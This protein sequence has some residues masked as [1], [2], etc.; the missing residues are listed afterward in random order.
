MTDEGECYIIAHRAD[1]RQNEMASVK[2]SGSMPLANTCLDD[3]KKRKKKKAKKPKREKSD[4][5]KS[6]PK[7]KQGLKD[8]SDIC[9]TIFTADWPEIKKKKRKKKHGCSLNEEFFLT[10]NKNLKLSKRNKLNRKTR[11]VA[12][13]RAAKDGVRSQPG[14]QEAVQ[15][16]KSLIR[17]EKKHNKRVV[18]NLPPVLLEPKPLQDPFLVRDSFQTQHSNA[19]F[20]ADGRHSKPA[21]EE[22]GT[23][24]Q[25]TS[26]DI[27]SQDL[28]ITQKTFSDPYID[29]C[30]STSA[31]EAL[32]PQG[33]TEIHPEPQ[34]YTASSEKEPSREPQSYTESVLRKQLC[35]EHQYYTSSCPD[36][37]ASTASLTK[38]HLYP[39]HHTY[40]VPLTRNS[41]CSEPQAPIASS[42]K[43]LSS[44]EPQ[45]YTSSSS[46]P[47]KWSCPEPQSLPKK[48]LCPH[49]PSY[50]PSPLRKL[51]HGHKHDAFTQTE[52]FFTAPLLATSLGFRQQSKCTEEPMD[53]SL[54]KRPQREAVR[55]A[56][57][58][59]RIPE[60]NVTN[61][62]QVDDSDSYLK[63]KADLSQLKVVQTRLNESF[64]FKLKGEGDSPKPMSPLM[65]LAGSVEKKKP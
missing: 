47:R 43:K 56:S 18:F 64:F 17:K 52:N 53:L 46:S 8:Y 26:D 30:S 57:G 36:P 16:I 48:P 1:V 21:M 12:D 2:V 61:L 37:Q 60:P 58:D 44:P 54:P 59:Q 65:K 34:S 3:P 50:H 39:V 14:E 28:F 51:S 6:K 5:H 38:K 24:S 45:S 4:K 13:S 11:G 20:P 10:Q 63:S 15:P 35:P 31:E 49:H 27:N 62:T 19:R 42:A 7:G 9:D 41:P 33:Y 22:N 23:G 25:T 32:E 55:R 40:T 29:L